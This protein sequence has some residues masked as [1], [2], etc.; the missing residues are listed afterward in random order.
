MQFPRFWSSAQTG[1]LKVWGWSDESVEHA[2]RKAVERQQRVTKAFSV[3]SDELP[4]HYGYGERPLREEVLREFTNAAD[5]RTAV[6]SRNSMGCRVLNTADLMFV[7]IDEMPSGGGG[8]WSALFGRKK[9]PEPT[10]AEKIEAQVG[11]WVAANPRWRWRIYQTRAGVR[12]MAVHAA[13]KSDDPVVPG[14]FEM[15]GAD[16]LYR[17]LCKDQECFR[18]RLTPKPFRCDVGRPPVTWPF[19]D[20]GTKAAMREWERDYLRQ[21]ASFSTC[22]FVA[23]VGT[24]PARPEFAEF[25][26]IHDDAT[27]AH[28]NL[29]LA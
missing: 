29:A 24:S 13:V 2:Q 9:V 18:A 26:Q 23:E 19:R 21:A 15:F 5:V 20:A 17:Q 14:V 10:L 4:R 28:E 16:P 25:I 12:L 11:E 8:F 7:D 3:E 22:R 6:I 1:H 27:Q